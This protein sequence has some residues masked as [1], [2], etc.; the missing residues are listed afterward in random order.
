[1]MSIEE[2]ARNAVTVCMGVRRG[3]RVTVLM[4]R[5]R[6][7][8]ARAIFNVSE[9]IGADPII[10]ELSPYRWE[11]KELP[12]HV[13]KA[14][15]SSDVIFAPTEKSISHTKARLAATKAGA[16]V[17]SMPGI[18]N[19]EMNGPMTA[20]FE[21]IAANVRRIYEAIRRKKKIV[22][23]S[24]AGTDI[25]MNVD[26]RM[27]IT[28]D[29]GLAREKGSFTNLPAGRLLAPIIERSAYGIIVVDGTLDNQRVRGHLKMEVN[30]GQ[31]VSLEG[32]K[33]KEYLEEVFERGG[34]RSRYIGGFGIGM[35][36]KAKV[37]G[38]PLQDEIAL[39]T[40]H[41]Y[42]GENV[43]FGG[44]IRAPVRVSALIKNVTVKIGEI[45][46]IEEGEFV[47]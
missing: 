16:R 37:V 24:K 25:T 21:E 47:F 11:G 45:T 46:I 23:T 42:I 28:E 22:V 6:N 7:S 12:L 4:D 17:A 19:S 10:I 13:A 43:S 2:G 14:M 18:R 30:K 38:H 32:G 29:T 26:G 9:Q 36:P 27:W 39:G 44:R 33:E 31:V 1:M 5:P 41:F 40:A 15:I 34:K 35:N 20:D 3:E 8:I